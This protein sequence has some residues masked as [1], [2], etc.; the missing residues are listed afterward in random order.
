MT[1]SCSVDDKGNPPSTRFHWLRGKSHVMDMVSSEWIID[2]VSLKSRNNFS[3]YAI[4]DGGNGTIA[5]INVEVQ[6]VP[7]LIDPLPQYSGFLY[8]EPIIMLSC[9][10]E[11]FP[12][13]FVYWFLD[14]EE[15]SNQ[16]E[17]YFINETHL[18][19]D[20]LTGDFESILSELVKPSSLFY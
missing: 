17:R 8:S 5:T 15:I 6:V 4:N 1:L 10:F 9:R 20:S 2:P 16:N 3:C 18:A 11:C 7:T 13:C 14:G 12:K 19:A